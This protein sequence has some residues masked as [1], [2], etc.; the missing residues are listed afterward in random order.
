MENIA[1]EEMAWSVGWFGDRR[2]DKAREC[3]N[4]E[5][6]IPLPWFAG[7]GGRV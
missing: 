4:H 7:F 2:R 1:L 5:V 3:T 6:P